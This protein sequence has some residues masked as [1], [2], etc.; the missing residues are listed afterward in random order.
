[1]R[2]SSNNSVFPEKQSHHRPRNKSN[3]TPHHHSTQLIAMFSLHFSASAFALINF[4]Q[5][6]AHQLITDTSHELPKRRK[7]KKEEYKK[8]QNEMSI[9]E[10]VYRNNS[11]T[12]VR[13]VMVS[14]MA[15]DKTA[16]LNA[17]GS[18]IFEMKI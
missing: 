3:L 4:G 8:K 15:S 11:I 2:N 7:Q 10:S 5:K 1:M 13:I 6:A 9:R 12:Y 14:L 17:F 18:V 16:H